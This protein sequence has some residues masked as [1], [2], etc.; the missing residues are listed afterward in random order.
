MQEHIGKG[1]P[2][3]NARPSTRRLYSNSTGRTL[4]ELL[5][6]AGEIAGEAPAFRNHNEIQA[7]AQASALQSATIPANKPVQGARRC[8]ARQDLASST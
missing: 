5:G 6:D 3:L 8:I 7:V 1:E 2:R 4:R